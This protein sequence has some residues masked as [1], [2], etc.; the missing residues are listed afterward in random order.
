MKR[1]LTKRFWFTNIF[2]KE[3]KLST[4]VFIGV[5]VIIGTIA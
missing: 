1:L 5:L 4:N 3:V 2:G